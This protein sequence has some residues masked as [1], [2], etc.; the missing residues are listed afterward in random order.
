MRNSTKIGGSTMRRSEAIDALKKIT[1]IYCN[2]EPNSYEC[3]SRCLQLM[4]NMGML[5]PEEEFY[6]EKKLDENIT[7]VQVVKK[8]EW[9]EE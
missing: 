6:I 1:K 3:A 8:H 5:P 4:I 2:G 7:F 9:R